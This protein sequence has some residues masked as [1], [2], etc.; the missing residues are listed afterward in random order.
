MFITATLLCN[1]S[2]FILIVPISSPHADPSFT[3]SSVSSLLHTLSTYDIIVGSLGDVLWVPGDVEEEL[4]RKYPE[5]ETQ[6][7]EMVKYYINTHPDASW[8]HI[9]GQLLWYGHTTLS[10]ELKNKVKEE[11]GKC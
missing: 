7:Q 11:N 9:A 5:E 1:F 8:A 10:D 2:H 4:K 3:P 6:R